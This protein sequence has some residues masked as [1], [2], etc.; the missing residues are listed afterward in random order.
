MIPAWIKEFSKSLKYKVVGFYHAH[1][2]ATWNAVL[3]GFEGSLTK[4]SRAYIKKTYGD[5]DLVLTPSRYV[6][7]YLNQ[8][9][10][11]NTQ[12]VH[13]GVDSDL[14]SM[15]KADPNFLKDHNISEN[16]RILLFTGRFAQEKRIFKIID[17]FIALNNLHKNKYHLVLLGGGPEEKKIRTMKVEEMTVIPF[18]SDQEKLVSIYNSA[19]IFVTASNSETFGLTLL[20]AQCCGLPIVAFQETS[21]PEIVVKKELLA[22]TENDFIHNI[23]MIANLL[24]DN[25]KSEIRE[26]TVK[27]FSWDASF[28]KLFGIY[29]ELCGS[30]P[31]S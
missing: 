3:K 16:K 8:L 19:D 24:S 12:Y 31:H 23:E 1:I 6:E 25:L 29:H 26:Q 5:M 27:H 18:C 14:F 2:E 9:G 28:K 10:I 11:S 22:E 17:M 13:L 15:G 21:I 30:D 7:K 20:E 4:L